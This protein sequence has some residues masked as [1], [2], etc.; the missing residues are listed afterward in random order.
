MKLLRDKKS[1][2]YL[3]VGGTAF[4]V[5]YLVFILLNQLTPTPLF[6]SNAIALVL[7]FLVSFFGNR[8]IVFG[9][10]KGVKM[11]YSIQNQLYLYIILLAVNMLL[12]YL[13]IKGLETVGLDA[14]VGKIVAMGAI[15]CWNF[16]IYKRII[17]R[18]A[19]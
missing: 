8:I 17:F 18:Q 4:V 12:S 14:S 13:L 5:D 3:A 11:R 7:G 16:I 2:T 10:G 6:Y 19:G 9:S 15:I 1:I